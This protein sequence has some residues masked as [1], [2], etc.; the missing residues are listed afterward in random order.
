MRDDEVLRNGG[1][2]PDLGIAD[3]SLRVPCSYASV[4]GVDD[5]DLDLTIPGRRNG[6]IYPAR[7]ACCLLSALV[8]G[9]C[10]VFGRD[11]VGKVSMDQTIIDRLSKSKPSKK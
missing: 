6:P 1:L 10:M 8:V 4:L 2:E 11:L 5:F 9:S 7:P 3:L